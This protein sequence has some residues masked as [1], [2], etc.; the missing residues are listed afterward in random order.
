V[1]DPL[2]ARL[3]AA[4]VVFIGLAV[5]ALLTADVSGRARVALWAKS[6]ASLGFVVLGLVNADAA[7]AFDRWVLVGLVFAALGDVALALPGERVFLAGVGA[8]ALGHLAYVVAA[9]AHAWPVTAPLYAFAAIGPSLLAYRW[10]YPRLGKMRLPVAVYVVIITVMV[11]SAFALHGLHA[12]SGRLFLIGAL[13]FYASDLSV[14]RDRFVHRAFFNRAWGLP[15]YYAAQVCI[16]LSVA[17][18]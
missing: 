14:A 1:S 12:E 6:S 11:I 4:L 13:L 2:D 3:S 5:S 8:F 15:A 10:L 18:L 7:H 9:L 17:A 16:A